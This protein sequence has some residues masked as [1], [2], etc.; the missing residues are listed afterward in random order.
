M[1]TTSII[2]RA[3]RAST[4]GH[5]PV[6]LNAEKDGLV[7]ALWLGV[8]ETPSTVSSRL[9]R[10]ILSG[11][12]LKVLDVEDLIDAMRPVAD[13]RP[14]L[15]ADLV[16]LEF[17]AGR[18]GSVTCAMRVGRRLMEELQARPALRAQR[19]PRGGT[20]GEHKAHPPIP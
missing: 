1:S 3:I 14:N 4:Q 2:A 5:D 16:A 18:L 15:Q 19:F 12:S 10:L 17:V 7:V 20:V 8:P 11:Q 9:Q 6:R 13:A